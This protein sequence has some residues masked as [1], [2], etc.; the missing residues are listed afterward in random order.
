[1]TE[2]RGR[3]IYDNLRSL[4]GEPTRQ[5]SSVIVMIG[6]AQ[7]G[8]R[9][10]QDVGRRGCI[11]RSGI[12]DFRSSAPTDLAYLGRLGWVERGKW[13]LSFDRTLEGLHYIGDGG[14]I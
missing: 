1:M 11:G 3:T 8:D 5:N 10:A 13:L 14:T 12:P 7:L 2:L 6:G 4:V 9:P